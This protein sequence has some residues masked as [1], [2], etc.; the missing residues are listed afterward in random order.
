MTVVWLNPIDLEVYGPLY[1]VEPCRE[2]SWAITDDGGIINSLWSGGDA[3]SRSDGVAGGG[4]SGVAGGGPSGVAG[5]S[6]LNRLES[7]LRLP[8][9]WSYSYRWMISP[10]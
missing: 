10:A 4:P 8:H 9:S 6:W 7:G 2:G 5:V 3:G 1:S